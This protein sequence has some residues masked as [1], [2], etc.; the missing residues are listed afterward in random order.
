MSARVENFRPS[1]VSCAGWP[2]GFL[3]GIIL[4]Q[5]LQWH[6]VV[7]SAGYPADSVQNLEVNMLWDGFFHST[8]YMSCWASSSCGVRR[9]EPMCAGPASYSGYD[10]D[11]LRPFNLVEGIIDH[12]LLGIQHVN[13][14]VLQ[15]QWIYWDLGFLAWGCADAYWWVAAH[16][17]RTTRNPEAAHWRQIRRHYPLVPRN[18]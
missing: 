9:I 10:V 2:R 5:V 14:T 13:E 4:H 12:H 8:T 16:A 18:L 1:L 11:R 6:H 15:D 3:D 17:G 7:T